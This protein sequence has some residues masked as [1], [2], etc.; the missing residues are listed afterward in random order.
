MPSPWYKI[1][2]KDA[3]LRATGGR[4]RSARPPL[5]LSG[6][7]DRSD[8]YRIKAFASQSLAPAQLCAFEWLGRDPYSR[9]A[10]S[11]TKART[12]DPEAIRGRFSEGN[13]RSS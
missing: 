11:S 7:N 9:L 2:T 8:C 4:V 10:G 13:S 1:K 12:R 5:L 3:P 6:F